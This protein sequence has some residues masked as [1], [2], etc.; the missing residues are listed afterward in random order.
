MYLCEICATSLVLE[1]IGK[2]VLILLLSFVV[3]ID[4]RKD[5]R[6]KEAD[7]EIKSQTVT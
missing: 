3:T 6:Y 2:P 4:T 1:S 5:F 7:E